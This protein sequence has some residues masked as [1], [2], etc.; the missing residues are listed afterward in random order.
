MNSLLLY[1]VGAEHSLSYL[2]GFVDKAWKNHAIPI[3][4]QVD[5]EF[6]IARFNTAAECALVL[7]GEPYTI[8]NPPVILKSWTPNFDFTKEKITVLSIWVKLP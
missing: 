7:D 8:K 4:H 2:Q 5:N 3:L 1:V 6:F